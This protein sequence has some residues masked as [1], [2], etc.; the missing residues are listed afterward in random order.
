MAS[1]STSTC[2]QYETYLHS[3][4]EYCHDNGVDVFQPELNS[5]IETF[6]SLYHYGLRY[7]AVNNAHSALSSI[8]ILD[9]GLQ[10][11]EK[12]L[13]CLCLKGVFELKPAQPK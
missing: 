6:V 9:N 12:P 13:V 5:A 7:S 8:I 1:W 2:K 10:F 4:P 11:G 3:W